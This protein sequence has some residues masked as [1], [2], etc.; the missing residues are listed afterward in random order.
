MPCILELESSVARYGDNTWN[1]KHV[2]SELND[3][4]LNYVIGSNARSSHRQPS[5][6]A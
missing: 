5:A 2:N 4:L 3:K 1:Y 6:E